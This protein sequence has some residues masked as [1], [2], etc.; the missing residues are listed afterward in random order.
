MKLETE[1]AC[2]D[3]VMTTNYVTVSGIYA[4]QENVKLQMT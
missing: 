2:G 1:C 3:C 4:S